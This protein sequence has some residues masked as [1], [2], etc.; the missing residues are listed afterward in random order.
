MEE[1]R[2]SNAYERGYQDGMKKQMKLNAQ[3]EAEIRTDERA[4][5]K[6]QLCC[7]DANAHCEQ[8]KSFERITEQQTLSSLFKELDEIIWVD[9]EHPTRCFMV[10]KK[11]LALKKK[12]NVKM[13]D[14]Q[15]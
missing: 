7:F 9:D 2:E 4:K 10:I 6:K 14:A 8:K 11:Y 1:E 13:I 5:F 15:D 3:K 12:H